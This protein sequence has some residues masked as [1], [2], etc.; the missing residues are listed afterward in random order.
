MKSF[1]VTPPPMGATPRF[2]TANVSRAGNRGAAAISG[3]SKGSGRRLLNFDL[4]SGLFKLLLDGGRFVLIYAFLDGL[5]SA[6]NEVLGF[7]QAE[8]RDF[9]NGRSE[10]HTSELQSP[11]NLV[12][13]L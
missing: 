13:R 7:L 11:C 5:G 8:A 2:R 10:D 4:G 12:C 9:A 6:V 3:K 1:G